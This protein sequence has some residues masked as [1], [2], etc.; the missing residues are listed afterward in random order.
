MKKAQGVDIYTKPEGMS[1]KEW[2]IIEQGSLQNRKTAIS[3]WQEM[4]QRKAQSATPKKGAEP[5]AKAKAPKTGYVARELV[6]LN[7]PYAKPAA[8]VW[9]RRNGDLS[10][11]VQGGYK[12]DKKAG[13]PVNIGVPYG[14]TARLVLFYIMSAAAFSE[15]RKI[16]LG[17][18]FDAFLKTIGASPERRGLKTGARAVLN[19][20]ERLIN[21]SFKIQRSTE[22]DDFNIERLKVLPLI[23]DSEIWFSKKRGDTAQQGLWNSYVEISEELFQSLKRNPIPIDWD[24][25]LKI[26]KN[27]TALDFYALLTYESAKAHAAGKGRF[28]PWASLQEQMGSETSRL[29]NFATKARAAIK[30]IQKHYKALK[31]S[32]PEGGLKIEAASLPSIPAAKVVTTPPQR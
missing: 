6:L 27:P 22:T 1:E 29:N 2:A 8:D 24:I 25:V 16:Y 13:K 10:L 26:R 14:A 23:S 28:I 4:Q 20:L 5:P 18:S 31:V 11:I 7:L 21:A 9:T 19:Q 12:I 15:S 30:E 3:I 32:F 17:N